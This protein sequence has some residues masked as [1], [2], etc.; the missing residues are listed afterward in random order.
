MLIFSRAFLLAALER[1]IKTAAQAVLVVWLV[2]GELTNALTFDWQLAAGVG[3]AG[4]LVSVLTSVASAGV[5][6]SESPSVIE[7]R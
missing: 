4:F 2:P 5:G 1:A 3:A 7:E 6:P